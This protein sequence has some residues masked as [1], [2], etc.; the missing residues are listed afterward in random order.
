MLDQAEL[1]EVCQRATSTFRSWGHEFAAFNEA[2]N[3]GVHHSSIG[4]LRLAGHAGCPIC[5]LVCLSLTQKCATDAELCS[6][7]NN[8]NADS[9][10]FYIQ[11]RGLR[12][13]GW[14]DT[15]L[16]P[17]QADYGIE[18]TMELSVEVLLDGEFEPCLID[19]KFEFSVVAPGTESTLVFEPDS[20]TGSDR[21]LDLCKTWLERCTESHVVCRKMRVADWRPTRL[22]HWSSVING[23]PDSLVL[24]EASRGIDVHWLKRS[25]QDAI[26]LANHLGIK[27]LWVDTLSIVQ[28]DLVDLER[29]I[30][31]MDK[32]YSNAVCNIAASDASTKDEG[33]FFARDADQIRT[34][35]VS[36]DADSSSS[37][38]HLLR[39]TRDETQRALTTCLLESRAWVFQE[40][41]LAPR[42]VHCTT[43]QL[44][45]ECREVEA[46]ET[47]PLGAVGGR[48]LKA[49]F[50]EDSV[51]HI[52]TVNLKHNLWS[53]VV[54]EYTQ[55]ALTF[56]IDKL[57]AL[58]GIS[59]VWRRLYGDQYLSGLWRSMLP[60]HL[61]WSISSDEPRRVPREQSVAPSWSWA[62]TEGVVELDLHGVRKEQDYLATFDS[63]VENDTVLRLR[64]CVAQVR[65]ARGPEDEFFGKPQFIL[66]EPTA[67]DA[68]IASF[69]DEDFTLAKSS[70]YFDDTKQIPEMIHCLPIYRMD[71]GAPGRRRERVLGLVL[72]SADM[73]E[74]RYHRLGTFEAQDLEIRALL[75][76]P[77]ETVVELA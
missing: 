3:E 71:Y 29:E 44:Y 30:S 65:W 13:R 68:I 15:S 72:R 20:Y 26:V 51:D 27:Y 23:V 46:S 73:G 43:T 38:R 11:W 36:I 35:F 50:R 33:C 47:H 21:T 59:T 37:A 70:V 2:P 18:N 61:M 62:S 54:S 19:H 24:Y 34:A 12:R 42:A 45:W 40:R 39:P 14:Y 49:I 52:E 74:G 56:P 63:A 7:V 76:S 69:T 5:R 9:S 64:G 25:V 41:L 8:D 77:P 6:I 57:R 1:C 67:S 48:R 28:D 60:A 66:V 16:E 4:N 17:L 75:L 32:V 10:R 22:V 31:Q 58:A 55:R 53:M